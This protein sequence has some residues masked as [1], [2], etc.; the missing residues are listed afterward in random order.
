MT[1]LATIGA[2]ALYLL[3][4]WLISSIVASLLS[5]RKGYGEKPG[6]AT[7]LLLSAVAIIIWLA[8]PARPNSAWKRE[9]PIPRRKRVE[10]DERP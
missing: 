5:A 3:Y 7:G 10:R 8:W 9:G 4:I 1:P 6:L 2:T